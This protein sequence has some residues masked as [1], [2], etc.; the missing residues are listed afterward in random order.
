MST[1]MDLM[2]SI[3]KDCLIFY[4][5]DTE[6][7]DNWPLS[8]NE[9]KH[10]SFNKRLTY[11]DTNNVRLPTYEEIDHKEIMRFFVRECVEDKGNRKQLFDILKRGEYIDLFLDKL[12]ELKLYDDFIEAC[13][14]IYIQIFE[15]WVDKN[16]ILLKH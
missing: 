11:E 10:V 6:Q 15:E 8:E 5:R 13:E 4:H 16:E 1:I 3:R 2:L 7:F 12:H 14:E 9:L